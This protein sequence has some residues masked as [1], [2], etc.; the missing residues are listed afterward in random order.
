MN[1]LYISINHFLRFN[2]SGNKFKMTISTVFTKF[3]VFFFPKINT[4][5]YKSLYELINH[6]K[7]YI[8]IGMY[9]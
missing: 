5:F 4:Y 9:C 7:L 6:L 2:V 1:N 3:V 8:K